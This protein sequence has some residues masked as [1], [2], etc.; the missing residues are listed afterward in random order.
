MPARTRAKSG[1]ARRASIFQ[2]D[3]C[4]RVIAPWVF[5]PLRDFF[6]LAMT[7]AAC[8]REASETLE[9]LDLRCQFKLTD[10]RFRAA[11]RRFPNLRSIEFDFS[12][13]SSPTRPSSSNCRVLRVYAS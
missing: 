1:Q 5:Y 2:T 9:V 8:W 7:S 11:V 4:T 13:H 3:L 12:S 6:H 10:V